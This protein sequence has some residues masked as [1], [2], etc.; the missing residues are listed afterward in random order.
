MDNELQ[1]ILDFIKKG[2]FTIED[3]VSEFPEHAEHALEIAEQLEGYVAFKV[4][5][6]TRQFFHGNDVVPPEKKTRPTASNS[7]DVTDVEYPE[8]VKSDRDKVKFLTSTDSPKLPKPMH[9]FIDDIDTKNTGKLL[10]DSLNSNHIMT[11]F[12]LAPRKEGE[13]GNKIDYSKDVTQ[14][15]GFNVTFREGKFKVNVSL[16][17]TLQAKYGNAKTEGIVDHFVKEFE[18][19]GEFKAWISE[20]L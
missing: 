7:L 13:L 2:C 5:S 4:I 8:W 9:F 6:K 3:I 11:S 1:P 16:L 19:Y 17:R 15:R 14:M 20:N 12:F 18:T 10:F